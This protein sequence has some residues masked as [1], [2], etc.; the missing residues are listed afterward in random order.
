M[1]RRKLTEILQKFHSFGVFLL[2]I[3]EA[4]NYNMVME[5]EKKAITEKLICACPALKEDIDA[6]CKEFPEIYLHLLFGDILNPYLLDLLNNANRNKVQL[7]KIAQLLELM[8]GSDEMLQEVV[9]TT[10]L[11]RLSDEPVKI[12]RFKE[13]AGQITLNFIKGLQC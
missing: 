10:V 7:T 2:T 4:G 13:F 9:M 5:M 11:E 1:P 12:E 8:S 6:H 3:G